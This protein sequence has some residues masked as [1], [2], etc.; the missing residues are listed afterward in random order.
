MGNIQNYEHPYLTV[1]GVIFRF[2][3]NV[4]QVLLVHRDDEF[5]KWA[6]PGGFVDID[7]LADDTLRQKVQAKTGVHGFYSEQLKTYDSLNRDSRGRV[8]SIAYLCLLNDNEQSG[9]WF[10]VNTQ[11]NL[12][13][14]HESIKFEDLSFDHGEILMDAIK[15]LTGKLW[16]SDLASFLLPEI[17][18]IREIETLFEI[19]E[20]K[21]TGMIRRQLGSRIKE[22]GVE[23]S[24]VGRP[25]KLY[26]WV[27]QF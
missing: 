7:K 23:S 4:L 24:P 2:K 14:A 9:D 13:V 26:S 5:G 8:I 11:E 20:E 15:R 19:L 17:F 18:T 12:L 1:D 16:W 27:N 25:A 21:K 10:T 3:N 6:L 22:V